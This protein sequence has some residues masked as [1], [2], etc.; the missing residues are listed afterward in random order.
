[1]H[2]MDTA[3]GEQTQQQKKKV[4][5]TREFHPKNQRESE[6]KGKTKM[7]PS[8]QHIKS[9]VSLYSHQFKLLSRKTGADIG[10]PG[11]TLL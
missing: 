5:I 3:D 6:K 4:L 9:L 7:F 11:S 10:V 2:G 8:I 1:M